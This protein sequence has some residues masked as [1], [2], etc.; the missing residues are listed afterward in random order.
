LRCRS[1]GAIFE[2]ACPEDQARH[3]RRADLKSRAP[4]LKR[5]VI[6]HLVLSVIPLTAPFAAAVAFYWGMAHKQDLSRMAALYLALNRLAV[7]TGLG[8]TLLIL[9]AVGLLSLVGAS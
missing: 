1:C 5:R 9:L 2:S 7:L 6:A 4:S 8:Q 3:A